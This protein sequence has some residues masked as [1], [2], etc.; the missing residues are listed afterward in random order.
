MEKRNQGYRRLE[1]DPEGDQAPTWTA[2][3]MEVER[4]RRITRRI[5]RKPPL[6]LSVPSILREIYSLV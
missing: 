1:F 6:W 5:R 3:P 4:R 2:E